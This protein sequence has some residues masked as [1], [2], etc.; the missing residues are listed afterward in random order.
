[1]YFSEKVTSIGS[2]AFNYCRRLTSITLP[3]SVASLESEAFS[4][5]YSLK[6]ITIPSSLN[7]IGDQ[8]FS[9]CYCVENFNITVTDY[10]DF[11]NNNL[12]R[13][14]K[15]FFKDWL[16][17][18]P[19]STNITLLDKDGNEIKEYKIPDGV[20]SINDYAFYYC[21]GLTSVS[22]PNSV[23]SIGTCAFAGCNSLNSIT[24]PPNVISI[25][26]GAFHVPLNTVVS[27][28]EEPFKIHTL[29]PN[30]IYYNLSEEDEGVFSISNYYDATLYVPK[31]TIDK[32]K[33]TEGWKD[34][35]HIEENNGE[36]G[37]LSIVSEN[38]TNTIYSIKGNSL[39]CP[40]K[41]INIIK[42]KNGT[43]KKVLIK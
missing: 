24:I 18:N 35:A 42:M 36:T 7:D 13:K 43:A 9:Q 20:T 34:F 10:S 41:G 31:G 30:I 21:V 19:R 6:S 5:C 12:L 2:M 17:P 32:Y 33:A 8:P 39:Q 1:V 25:G 4:R 38:E 27:L 15:Y 40:S 16:N 37:I 11:C 26:N 28:I 23:T 3:N 14:V 22:I 29:T